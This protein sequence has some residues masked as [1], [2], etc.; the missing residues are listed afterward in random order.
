M[1]D[2]K[3]I[4]YNFLEQFEDFTQEDR[5]NGYVKV[6]RP[7]WHPFPVQFWFNPPYNENGKST[8]TPSKTIVLT[9]E[10]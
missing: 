6:Y 2:S 8:P 3:Q 9:N 10:G 1:E 7:S 4:I 5:E